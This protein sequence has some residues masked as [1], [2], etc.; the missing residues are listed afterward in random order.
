M[1]YIKSGDT[2]TSRLGT[3]PSVNQETIA[4]ITLLTA[5]DP[6]FLFLSHVTVKRQLILYNG[7]GNNIN[8]I[9]C[10]LNLAH[11][12]GSLWSGM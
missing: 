1:E 8:N 11:W 3:G 9:L 5:S 7:N 6:V 2:V 12:K 4:K 10:L